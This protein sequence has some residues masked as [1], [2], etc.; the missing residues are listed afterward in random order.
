M[1]IRSGLHLDTGRNANVLSHELQE[2]A[3]DR[4]QILRPRHAAAGRSADDRLLQGRAERDARA[5][6]GASRGPAA[7]ADAD[8][9]GRR[10]SDVGGRRHHLLRTRP[11]AR[12]AP[13]E[14]LRVFEAAVSRNVPVADDALA[15]MERELQI[16]NYA[17]EVFHPTP[18]HR[19]R[20]V[21]F[22]RPR[23]GLSAR[24]SEMRDCGLLGAI[25]P[26]LNEIS[27]RVTRDFYHKYTVDEHTLLTVRN[28]E[29]AADQPS[30]RP[31]SAR[32]ARA[33]A[34]GARAP[35][36]RRG[37]SARRR[38]LHCR[39]RDGRRTWR[40]GWSW[41]QRH[42][43]RSTFSSATISRCRAIAFRRDTEEPEVVRQF[44]SLFSTEEHLKMLVLLTLCDV[45]AVSP[46][47]LTPWKEELLW[48]LY[49]DAYNQ[50]TLGYG[51]DIIDREQALGGGSPGQSA[52]RH[53]RGRNG[54]VSRGPAR[55]AICSSFRTTPSTGMSG[56]RAISGP[57]RRTLFSKRRPMSGS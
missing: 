19:Q 41:T 28:A 37:Q 52:G 38:P 29:A 31:G 35:V 10:K 22:L 44:A 18:E 25:F 43:R 3:V 30:L 49:V 17:P 39:R 42:G 26:E 51:D 56:F 23:P 36:S 4:L 11:K 55:V 53:P 21:Q 47:T 48:R 46:D 45:G 8:P 54:G 33:R 20:V 12:R 40:R 50:M 34:A 27:C 5:R 14:W 57:T 16:H 15:L 7:R 1:R 9:P 24:L 6:P 13:A 2:K 32:A